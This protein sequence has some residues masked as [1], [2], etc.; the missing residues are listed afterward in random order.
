[1]HGG[2]DADSKPRGFSLP[3]MSRRTRVMGQCRVGDAPEEFLPGVHPRSGISALFLSR[4]LAR[5]PSSFHVALSR[6]PAQSRRKRPTTIS[7]LFWGDGLAVY[8][9][10]STS[11]SFLGDGRCCLG[12][13]REAWLSVAVHRRRLF[14]SPLPSAIFLMHLSSFQIWEGLTQRFHRVIA[15]DFVGFGFSDKP[16]SS[17]G[18]GFL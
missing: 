15:L 7:W 12:E 14:L 1:M 3:G 10:I 4:H 13:R 16:V 11:C 5:E 2:L 8:W 6:T 9:E 17:L 18:R